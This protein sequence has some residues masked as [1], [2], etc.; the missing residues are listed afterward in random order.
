[1]PAVNVWQ[2]L[3]LEILLTAI[4]MFVIVAVATDTRSVWQMALSPSVARWH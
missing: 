3:G 1:V 4:L 2:S